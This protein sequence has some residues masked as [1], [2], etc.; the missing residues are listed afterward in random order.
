MGGVMGTP[1]E[2]KKYQDAPILTK[3]GTYDGW[4]ADAFA[5]PSVTWNGSIFAMTASMW[6]NTRMKWASGFFTSTLLVSNWTYVSGSLRAPQG[7]DYILGN[8]GI[9]WFKNRFYFAYLHYPNP[10][11]G[12]ALNLAIQ[13]ST[14]LL[15]WTTDVDPLTTDSLGNT[16]KQGDPGLN[17][18]PNGELELW[19]VINNTNDAFSYSSTDGV[20]WTLTSGVNGYNI[21][22]LNYS[23]GGSAATG[24]GEAHCLVYS[25]KRYLT[26]DQ[27]NRSDSHDGRVRVMFQSA[28]SP[29][30]WDTPL[31]SCLGPSSVNSMAWQVVQVFDGMMFGPF[32]AGGL[33]NVFWKVFAG[34][35]N[36]S[37][38]DNTDSSIGLAWMQAPGIPP[39]TNTIGLIVKSPYRNP[40][41]GQ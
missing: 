27:S 23:G 14:D 36:N 28:A 40:I 18:G 19:T 38:T 10:P 7:S 25:G 41:I 11:V 39:P 22:G 1:F 3:G 15:N 26:A 12:G 8:G 24:F 6:D 35:D 13:H 2:F 37:G 30:A 4:K 5:A 32:N 33:T 17:I 21:G 29:V 16:V 31:G 20:T 9:C 34:G